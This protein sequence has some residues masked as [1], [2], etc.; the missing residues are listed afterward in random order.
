MHNPDEPQLK[1]K[2]ART[3]RRKD[4]AKFFSLRCLCGLAS[5]RE[6]FCFLLQTGWS[7]KPFMAGGATGTIP[8]T[9]YARREPQ[10]WVSRVR[11]HF[12]NQ[13]TL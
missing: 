5:L 4:H 10:Q 11:R 8:T 12:Q 9:G 7:R 6:C 1:K 2:K 13:R 3:Q